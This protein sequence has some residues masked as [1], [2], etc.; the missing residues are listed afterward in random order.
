MPHNCILDA[1]TK[2]DPAQQQR[3]KPKGEA[4]GK[5]SARARNRARSDG[6]EL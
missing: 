5:L 6:S 2:E 4:K 3:K 1:I